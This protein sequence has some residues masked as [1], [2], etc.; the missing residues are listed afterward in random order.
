MVKYKLKK[1]E[2]SD[3][4]RHVTNLQLVLTDYTF[5]KALLMV[6]QNTVKPPIV[7]YNVKKFRVFTSLLFNDGHQRKYELL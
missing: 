3:S 5:V 4:S 2:R 6:G 1:I 7:V